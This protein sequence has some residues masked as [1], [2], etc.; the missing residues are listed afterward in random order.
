MVKSGDK[1]FSSVGTIPQPPHCQPVLPTLEDQGQR[2]G[3][4]FS[5]RVRQDREEE[6]KRRRGRG[7]EN[8]HHTARATGQ[9]LREELYT[10]GLCYHSPRFVEDTKA[11]KC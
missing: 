1:S 4:R 9:A 5:E 7:E 10:G 6:A 3:C 2:L 11:Q 8:G